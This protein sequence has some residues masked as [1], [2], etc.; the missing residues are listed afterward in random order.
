VAVVLIC[1]SRVTHMRM[2]HMIRFIA[3]MNESQHT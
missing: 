3:H 1:M 2:K